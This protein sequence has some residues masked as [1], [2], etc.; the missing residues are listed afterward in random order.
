MHRVFLG[1]DPA[2]TLC[3][4]IRDA[5]EFD[6]ATGDRNMR[7][8][9]NG[10]LLSLADIERAAKT[11]HE[12]LQ[13]RQSF[14]DMYTKPKFQPKMHVWVEVHILKAVAPLTDPLTRVRIYKARI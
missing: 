1:N 2:K 10:F 9:Q 13:V 8:S 6:I 4:S 5:R 14:I 11:V 12:H 3:I 7:Q